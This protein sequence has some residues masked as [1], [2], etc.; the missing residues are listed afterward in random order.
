[1]K[2]VLMIVIDSV[3]EEVLNSTPDVCPF[4]H[5][6]QN[7]CLR[8]TNVYS[9]GPYTEAGT[10]G[11]LCGENTLDNEGYYFRYSKAENFISSIFK[12]NGYETTSIIYPSTLYNESII[13]KLD[14]IYHTGVFLP[15]VFWEQKLSFYQKKFEEGTLTDREYGKIAD[16][17][18]DILNCWYYSV[19]NEKYHRNMILFDM[20]NS[21]YPYKQMRDY[22]WTEKSKFEKDNKAYINELFEKEGMSLKKD[23]FEKANFIKSKTL[24]KVLKKRK[25][26]C[27][28]LVC[29]Q[30]RLA[31]RQIE[32]LLCLLRKSESNFEKKGIL[33][34]WLSLLRE[35][36]DIYKVN[37]SKDFK[38]LLSARAQLDF[39]ADCLILE[40]E[41]PQFVM[42]H[43]EEPHYYNSFFSY[44]SDDLKLLEE[45]F[46]YAEDFL[47]KVDVKQYKGFLYYDLSI[48]YVDLQ[49]KKMFEKLQANG[50]LENTVVVITSDH[51]SSYTGRYLRMNR[52]INF[53]R[54]NYNIPFMIYD[55]GIE[56]KTFSELTSNI[57]IIPTVLS[58]L[59]IKKT[60][61]LSG[62]D[63]VGE[64]GRECVFVEYMGS[65][66]PDIHLR[67]VWLA[68]RSNEYQIAYVGSLDEIFS[69][70]NIVSIYDLKN[71]PDE[72]NNIV[73]YIDINASK[74]KW[75]R[76]KLEE[77]FVSLKRQYEM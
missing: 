19:D 58:I 45:E 9:Q 48:R 21:E 27:R 23:T 44:D 40:K 7:H 29:T 62:K 39:A 46:K 54:E 35:S 69:D 11:L 4:L 5:S 52:V 2:D 74:I 53:H 50:K 25:K 77:R 17:I 37:K 41:N 76:D 24:K 73:E 1:M 66:C 8:F 28:K 61:G 20:Y 63:I 49:I 36:S 68:V 64:G 22:V 70:D 12:D 16:L 55:T 14:N 38:L 71:D 75:L 43:V 30:S 72:N 10:K 15:N 59:G 51:G 60:I 56:G 33:K 31:L 6:I 47:E 13:E 26:F 57:D 67:P 34:V 3:F 32:D 18:K 42:V 65:G